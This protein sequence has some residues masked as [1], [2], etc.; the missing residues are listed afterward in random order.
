MGR[1]PTG[2]PVGEVPGLSYCGTRT[3]VAHRPDAHS[4]Y[5]ETAGEL[6]L[7]GLALLVAALSLPVAAALRARRSRFASTGLAAIVAWGLAS[8]VDWHWEMVGLTVTALIAGSVG[9]L[10]VERARA[11]RGLTGTPNGVLVVASIALSIAAV[12]A[13]WATGLFGDR[14]L[15]PARTGPPAVQDGRRARPS[16]L[17]VRAPTSCSACKR[18]KRR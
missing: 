11:P 18:R 6:G 15:S 10:A 9:M 2:P 8:A 7:V 16:V 13:S 12:W 17:V 1:L 3:G 5:L 4:L 14:R